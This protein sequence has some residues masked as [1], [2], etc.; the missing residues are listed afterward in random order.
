[1]AVTVTDRRT[2]VT[3]AESTTDWTGASYGTTTVSA[4]HTYAVAASLGEFGFR[5]SMANSHRKCNDG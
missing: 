4:E 2:E 5:Q 1:M 3:N